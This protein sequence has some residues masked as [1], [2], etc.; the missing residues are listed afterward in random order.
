MIKV[1]KKRVCQFCEQNVDF[2]DFKDD[3]LLRRFMTEQGKILP[4]HTT[5]TCAKHQ[6]QLSNAIKNAR[7]LA[8]LPFVT[9]FSR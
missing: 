6:R 7:H 2:I 9:D 5:G 4:K 3:R 1:R 8:I